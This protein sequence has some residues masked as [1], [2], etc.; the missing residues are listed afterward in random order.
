MLNQTTMSSKAILSRAL[1]SNCTSFFSF[2]SFC[3]LFNERVVISNRRGASSAAYDFPYK[4]DRAQLLTLSE[5]VSD[6]WSLN[7]TI[8]KLASLWARCVVDRPLTRKHLLLSVPCT[9]DPC[10]IVEEVT[11]GFKRHSVQCVVGGS[12]AVMIYSL[13]RV[14]KDVDFNIDIPSGDKAEALL[15]NICKENC[16]DLISI[17]NGQPNRNSVPML[18]RIRVGIAVI[19]VKGVHLIKLEQ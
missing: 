6:V 5:R 13:P 12:L 7:T 3:F 17:L 14:T 8:P 15:R 11:S 2:S 1:R 4:L 10:A 9:S 19:N 18:P 16:W